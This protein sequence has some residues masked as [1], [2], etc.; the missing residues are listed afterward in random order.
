MDMEKTTAT[1]SV[2]P[3]KGF[4]I[5]VGK[6]N[7]IIACAAIMIGVAIWLNWMFFAADKPA[8]SDGYDGYESD[9]GMTNTPSAG[10]TGSSD[11][12]FTSVQVNRQRARDEAIE[13]L[14]SVVDQEGADE[15][16]KNQALA[17]IA[18][19]AKEMNAESNIETLIES[20]G[21]SKCVAVINGEKA[22]I[23]VACE[24]ELLASQISQINEI[25]YEQ[26]GIKPVNIKIVKY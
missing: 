6:R 13:V 21:F 16:V 24:D 10:E 17:E 7:I 20:K 11:S 1:T 25:V 23:V 9:S 3:V 22:N 14:Q 26:A 4:I 19:I 18:Q 2:G 5:K 15:A 12:Y 8:G